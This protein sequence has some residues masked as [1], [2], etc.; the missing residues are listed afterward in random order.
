MEIVR[1]LCPRVTVMIQGRVAAEGTLDE[2]A[3]LPGGD[4]SLLGTRRG[5]SAAPTLEVSDLSAGYV[6]GVEI[7]AGVSL[8]AAENAVTLVIGPNG[9][10]KST[11]LRAIFG[12]LKPSA[13]RVSF[14]GKDVTGAN[15]EHAQGG[16]RQLRDAGHQQ[17]PAAHGGGE[18]ADGR[19]GVPPRPAPPEP[20]ARAASMP[21]FRS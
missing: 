2:V 7:L 16:W 19:L 21:C 14:R 8:T 10:G 12:I 4:R 5:M 3:R 15:S 11:L 9:A 6:P 20:P 1:R 17:F 18:P 13:G